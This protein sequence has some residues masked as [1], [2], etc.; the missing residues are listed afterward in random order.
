M[1]PARRAESA[2]PL[3]NVWLWRGRAERG[4]GIRVSN[5]VAESRRKLRPR[6]AGLDPSGSLDSQPRTLSVFCKSSSGVQIRQGPASVYYRALE[7]SPRPTWEEGQ[8]AQGPP[9]NVRLQLAPALTAKEVR[10]CRDS[11]PCLPTRPF[12]TSTVNRLLGT[13]H[14]VFKRPWEKRKCDPIVLTEWANF[15][16]HINIIV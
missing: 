11:P 1:G 8:A 3:R 6:L 15:L 10:L 4:R 14:L 7:R 13:G 5:P 2:T 9:L 16:G 12:P